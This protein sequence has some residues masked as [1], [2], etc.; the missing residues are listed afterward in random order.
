MDKGLYW[1]LRIT[2]GIFGIMALFRIVPHL[3]SL[4]RLLVELF[5]Q[6][7]TTPEFKIILV[8]LS[9]YVTCSVF[10]LIINIIF[11]LHSLLED[12]LIEKP[13]CRKRKVI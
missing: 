13:K 3:M 9:I 12:K 7:D 6:T 10:S 4:I 11:K 8:C 5:K 1:S 2:L